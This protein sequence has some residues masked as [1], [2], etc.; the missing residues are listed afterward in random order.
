MGKIL[1]DI[2]NVEWSTFRSDLFMKGY[3]GSSDASDICGAG[4]TS[5]SVKF[6]QMTGRIE[7][8]TQPTLA[9]RVGTHVESLGLAILNEILLQLGLIKIPFIKPAYIFQHNSLDWM[10]DSPDGV[11]STGEISVVAEIKIVSEYSLKKYGESGTKD[12]P[13]D[14]LIQCLHHMAVTGAAMCYLGV[15]FGNKE[16]RWFPITRDDILIGLLIEKETA[17]HECFLTD[18]LPEVDGSNETSDYLLSRFPKS[19]GGLLLADNISLTMGQELRDLQSKIKCLQEKYDTLKNRLKVS[20][21]DSEG[22][23]GVCTWLNQ[24]R[25]NLNQKLLKEKHPQIYEECL[26][27]S[28]SRVF[29][30]ITL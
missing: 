27:E 10:I 9:Q 6:C 22:I 18:T 3:I 11:P 28:E 24:T 21:G 2:P 25:K 19:K 15:V 4:Y 14:K 17:F 26:S 13:L 30:L 7:K 8:P 20:I 12:V 23:Q 29:R 16:F 5:P 1:C